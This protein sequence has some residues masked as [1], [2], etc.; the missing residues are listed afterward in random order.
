MVLVLCVSNFTFLYSIFFFGGGNVDRRSANGVFV[1]CLLLAKTTKQCKEL[2]INCRQ[3]NR[4]A[5]S[6]LLRTDEHVA[7]VE[8]DLNCPDIKSHKIP[9]NSFSLS[10]VVLSLVLSP[11]IVFILNS[12]FFFIILEVA[13]EAVTTIYRQKEREQRT[14]KKPIA[15]NLVLVQRDIL[16]CEQS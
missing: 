16:V 8:I 4:L 3:S 14:K 1:F 6:T 12:I 15:S 2:S 11:A 9:D 5:Q 7:Q 10:L 13:F